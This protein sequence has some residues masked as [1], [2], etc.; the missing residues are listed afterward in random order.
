ML[1]GIVDFQE[2]FGAKVQFQIEWQVFP[3]SKDD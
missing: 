1:A 2:F 3:N